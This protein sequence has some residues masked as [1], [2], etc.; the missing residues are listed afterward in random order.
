MLSIK[1]LIAASWSS[2]DWNLIREPLQ[3]FDTISFKE[4]IE[5]KNLFFQPHT[6]PDAIKKINLETS[7]IMHAQATSET[8]RKLLHETFD[9]SEKSITSSLSQ[10]AIV[11]TEQLLFCTL[12]LT[13][14]PGW[15]AE[16]HRQATKKP[17]LLIQYLA[18]RLTLT[19]DLWPQAGRLIT[20]Y[21]NQDNLISPNFFETIEKEE[22]KYI[23]PLLHKLIT[24]NIPTEKKNPDAQFIFCV[25]VREEA[26]RRTL[27]SFKNY[28]TYGY[29]GS[30]GLPLTIK[31]AQ[32]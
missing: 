5:Q 3:L 7:K 10:L 20:W 32:S 31:D 1:D 6:V 2:L 21:K 25:D 13:T 30:F 23:S 12:L 24:Q 11:E 29:A 16:I 22:K 26:F 15:A 17:D 4:A 19:L 28:Q 27:E 18:L 9:L 14:L 8:D